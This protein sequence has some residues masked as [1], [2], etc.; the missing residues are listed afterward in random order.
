MARQSGGKGG[1]SET[2]AGARA[3]AGEVAMPRV[4]IQVGGWWKGGKCSVGYD[5]RALVVMC[6]RL[7]EGE[8][9]RGV[10]SGHYVPRRGRMRLWERRSDLHR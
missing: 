5:S 6:Q 3:E 7:G 4:W 1:G 2:G 9:R 8:R 10:R